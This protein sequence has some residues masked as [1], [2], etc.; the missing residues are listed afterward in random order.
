MF[1]HVYA[2]K[3]N[4]RDVCTNAQKKPQIHEKI[5]KLCVKHYTNYCLM[6]IKESVEKVYI[7]NYN[8]KCI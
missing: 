8:K 1:L 3:I 6:K 2:Q 4:K 7:Y 5:E